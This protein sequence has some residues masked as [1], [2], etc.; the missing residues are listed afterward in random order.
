VSQ[1]PT[2]ILEK[3]RVIA[4]LAEHNDPH[5]VAAMMAPWMRDDPETFVQVALALAQMADKDKYVKAGHSA[6]VQGERGQAIEDLERQYQRE[7][8]KRIREYARQTEQAE[9]NAPLI[10]EVAA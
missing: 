10:D 1:L 9:L 2:E 5:L 4:Q 7:R 8:K 3:A 6:Y